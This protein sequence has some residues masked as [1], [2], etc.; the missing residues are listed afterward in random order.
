I[1][2]IAF[3]PS[4]LVLLVTLWI[5]IMPGFTLTRERNKRRL[6]G[7]LVGC[8]VAFVLFKIDPSNTIYFLIMWLLYTL[9]LCFLPVNYLYGATFVTVFVMI[10]SYFL[11]ESGTFVMHERL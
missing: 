11:H 4:R 3:T 2:H 5:V 6:I 1:V 10:A 8:A 9:A 7:T